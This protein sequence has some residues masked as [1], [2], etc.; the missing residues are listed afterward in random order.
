MAICTILIKEKK[1]FYQ[2][3]LPDNIGNAS[4][5]WVLYWSITALSRLPGENLYITLT[6]KWKQR[7]SNIRYYSKRQILLL[8][9]SCAELLGV[10]MNYD[11]RDCPIPQHKV[12]ELLYLR[13]YSIIHDLKAIICLGLFVTS[14]WCFEFA[15]FIKSLF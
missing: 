2:D 12:Y 10:G 13:Y 5:S 14:L 1:N 6:S 4:A 11:N 15:M 7:G 9:S 3:W 8:A